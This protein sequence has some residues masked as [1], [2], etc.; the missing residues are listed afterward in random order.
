MPP[1]MCVPHIA[2]HF[3]SRLL[4]IEALKESVMRSQRRCSRIASRVTCK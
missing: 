2:L 4:S 1:R 3:L